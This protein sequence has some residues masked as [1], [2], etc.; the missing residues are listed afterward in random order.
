MDTPEPIKSPNALR[1]PGTFN[2][3]GVAE[4]YLLLAFTMLCWG[5]NS[6][7]GRLAVGQVSP[8]VIVCLRW[9]IVAGI[10]AAIA[11]RGLLRAWP[12]L[13]RSWLKIVLMALA[14]FSIFNALY[15]VAAHHTTAVNMSILQGSIPILVVAGALILHRTGVGLFQLV[16]IALTLIGVAVVATAGHL[17][18]LA[19]FQLNL[20]DGLILVACVLYAGYTLA[21]R[22]R[23]RVSGLIFF[24]AMAI[25]AF[26]SSLPLLGYEVLTRTVQ[27]PTAEG[28]LILAFIA[29]FPSF[30]SQLSFMRAVQLIGPGRAGL[31]INL[32]PLFGALLAVLLLGEP[33]AL[34]H[35]VALVLIIGGILAAEV[36]GRS[37]GSIR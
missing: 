37:A 13:R 27:W 28:W 1:M 16:G 7:A 34:F 9:A 2:P 18:T 3:G 31:F 19:A 21:L 30:L 12:E 8:M 14:G 10:L 20:G 17:G 6:V 35:L 32:V 5:A 29:L 22:N 33:F 15:Y 36:S 11:S 4:A 25:A 26:F 24:A 23:P